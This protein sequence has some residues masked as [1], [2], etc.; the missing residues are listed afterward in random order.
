MKKKRK[1]YFKTYAL[2]NRKALSEDLF[3]YHWLQSLRV[4]QRCK[5]F[6][7]SGLF[8]QLNVLRYIDAI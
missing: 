8:F 2:S 6:A 7:I 3:P 4:K 1:K 5:L